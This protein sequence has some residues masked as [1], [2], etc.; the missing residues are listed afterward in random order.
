MGKTLSGIL[1]YKNLPNMRM[2]KTCHLFLTISFHFFGLH[3]FNVNYEFFL[4]KRF[5]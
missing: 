1:V 2:K 3:E 4:N 5:Q